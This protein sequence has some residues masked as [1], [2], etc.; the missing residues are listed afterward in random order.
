VLP[1][2]GRLILGI[3]K[4]IYKINC[5]GWNELESKHEHI[6]KSIIHFEQWNC[7]ILIGFFEKIEP[8]KKQ[9]HM[10]AFSSFTITM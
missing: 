6:R 7:K 5:N 3:R 10:N 4:N 8:E 1:F 9:E 2:L